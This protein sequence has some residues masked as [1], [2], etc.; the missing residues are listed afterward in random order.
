ME[1]IAEHLALDRRE[2]P[3]DRRL[4]LVAL[5]RLLDLLAK[6]RLALVA[7][8]HRSNCAPDAALAVL[9]V[10]HRW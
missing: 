2:V 6:G 3:D 10:S 5:D 9:F 8:Q 7:E 4:S 1:Q